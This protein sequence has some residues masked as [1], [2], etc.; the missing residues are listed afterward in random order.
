[1]AGVLAWPGRYCAEAG[2]SLP[3]SF[4]DGPTGGSG[5]YWMTTEVASLFGKARASVRA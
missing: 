3:F 5:N 4:E 2:R 1:M